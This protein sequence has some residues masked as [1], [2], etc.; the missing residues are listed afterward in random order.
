VL[1]SLGH[2]GDFYDNPDPN[3][4]R[5]KTLRI[6]GIVTG[7][8][9][10]RKH[11]VQFDS[12]Q[13]FSNTLRLETA[14]ASLP[15]E[16]VQAAVADVEAE[17]NHAEEAACIVQDNEAAANDGDEEH[18]PKKSPEAEEEEVAEDQADGASACSATDEAEP[19][20]RPVG[21]VEQ[22]PADNTTTYTGRRQA[23]LR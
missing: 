3:K 22:A 14:T 21:T 12:G 20:Q 19:A 1:A 11:T 6:Y 7:A 17:G 2:L 23:A 10:E 15:P 8:C 16:E 4:R 18:L 9:G 5:R 13:C